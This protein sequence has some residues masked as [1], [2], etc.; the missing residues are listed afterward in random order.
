MRYDR[1]EQI[2]GWDQT[3]LEDAKVVVIGAGALGNHYVPAIAALG[4]GEIKII[5][6]DDVELNNLN[7]Q[8]M[9]T[10]DDVGRNKAEALADR[11]QKRNSKVIITPIEEKVTEENYDILI[12]EPDILVDCVDL[13]YVRKLLSEYALEMGI[14]LIHGGISWNGWEASVLTRNTPCINCL[15]PKSTQE[16]ESQALA[17]CTDQH[18]SSVVYTG[19]MCG[20]FMANL[21]R[22]IL[23]PLESDKEWEGI[24]FKYDDSLE[25]PF[26][27]ERMRRLKNCDLCLPLLEDV[28]EESYNRAK[29]QIKNDKQNDENDLAEFL[30]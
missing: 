16:A 3:R 7:R 27:Q 19:Q 15:Y 9:F 28:D 6:F 30:D 22:K 26:Y 4:V 8:F 24:M 5:D 20:S 29:D 21:T 17:S 2:N 14:P 18:E 23:M 11:V 1:Q 25:I 13:I 10:E 12:G